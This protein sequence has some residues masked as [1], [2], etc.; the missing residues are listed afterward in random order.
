[1]FRSQRTHR[2]QFYVGLGQHTAKVTNDNRLIKHKSLHS[3]NRIF[4]GVRPHS[5]PPAPL[6]AH[7]SIGHG[8]VTSAF[9][10]SVSSPTT[11]PSRVAAFRALPPRHHVWQCNVHISCTYVC[12]RPRARRELEDR[13]APP[14]VHRPVPTTPRACSGP[15]LTRIPRRA[16]GASRVLPGLPK[17]R[18][19]LGVY[20]PLPPLSGARAAVACH[21]H[22]NGAAAAAG[23]ALQRRIVHFA[24]AQASALPRQ[25]RRAA[26]FPSSAVHRVA[27]PF[28]GVE[29]G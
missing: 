24:Y 2:G 11:S 8:T 25:M 3:T 21:R 14:C 23:C 5:P 1:M 6:Q 10:P 16:D 18:A 9:S 20:V 19:A 17:Q 28:P 15:T 13:A 7:T 22:R 4:R 29:Q 27:S 26:A 12:Q